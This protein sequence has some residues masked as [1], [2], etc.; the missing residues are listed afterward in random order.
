MRVMALRV[1]W[2]ESKGAGE[3]GASSAGPSLN[4][5]WG[6]SGDVMGNG[7]SRHV[8]PRKGGPLPSPC[9]ATWTSAGL[10]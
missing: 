6:W 2:L 8:K 10:L 4:P 3:G 9:S 5:F 1:W 7:S